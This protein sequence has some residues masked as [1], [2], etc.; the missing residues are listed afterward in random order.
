M[1]TA[2]LKQRS[3]PTRE[4]MFANTKWLDG[5]GDVTNNTALVWD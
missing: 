2:I 5:I 1:Y 4:R 3:Q